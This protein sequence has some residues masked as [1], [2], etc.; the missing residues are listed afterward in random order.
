MV[1]MMWSAGFYLSFVWMPVYMTSLCEIPVPAA[2]AVNSYA[3]FLGVC[4]LFPIAG[5][6]S[7]RYGRRLIMSIG[8]GSIV[9][10]SPH[11]IRTI[12][13]EGDTWTAFWNQL[14]LG[15]CL[16][17]WG[18]PMGAWLVE[19]FDP[20]ARLTSV[21]TGYNMAHAIAGGST[22]AVATW[23]VDAAGPSSPAW[24]YVCIACVAMLGLLV[25]APKPKIGESYSSII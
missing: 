7:D 24:I 5:W 12:G 4:V 23:L 21:S 20:E 9:L 3:L 2:F 16:S 17:F 15:I 1:P 6:L 11:L 13:G 22:P 18:S 14:I 10:L 25:V 19:S 8:G